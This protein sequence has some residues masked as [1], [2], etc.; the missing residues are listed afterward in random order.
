LHYSSSPGN[1]QLERI[2]QLCELFHQNQEI[3][4]ATI[5]TTVSRQNRLQKILSD[6]RNMGVA[7]SK[8]TH[9]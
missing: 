5:P 7:D 6:L 8:N 1:F 2:V 9:Y 3:A 4:T